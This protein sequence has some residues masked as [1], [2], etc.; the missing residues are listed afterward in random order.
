MLKKQHMLYQKNKNEAE[1]AAQADDAPLAE[2][3]IITDVLNV[4]EKVAS[5][6]VVVDKAATEVNVVVADFTC[7]LCDAVFNSMRGLRTHEGR[8]HKVKLG[9]PIPQL[10]GQSHFGNYLTYS[11]ISEYGQ[12]DIEYTLEEIFHQ[13]IN[14]KLISREKT[15]DDRSADQLC[16]VR[17]ELP[18]DDIQFTWPVMNQVLTDVFRNINQ[19]QGSFFLLMGQV[20]TVP[21]Y[22]QGVYLIS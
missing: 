6:E 19:M 7:E 20:Y 9:S 1:F 8:L 13:A 15:G 5:A 18:D 11:F 17:L 4:A 10:D 22:Q 2:E 12:Y 3:A 21:R 14:A 16:T